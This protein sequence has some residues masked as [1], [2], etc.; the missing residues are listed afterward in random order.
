M[1]LLEGLR[2]SG[3][4]EGSRGGLP[5]LGADKPTADD[6]VTSHDGFRRACSS[7]I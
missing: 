5:L 1:G 2:S 4:F 7:S 3:R 6:L